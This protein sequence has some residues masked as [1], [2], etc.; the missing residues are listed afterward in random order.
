TDLPVTIGNGGKPI[1]NADERKN[2]CGPLP[3]PS[4]ANKICFSGVGKYTRTNSKRDENVVF[5]VDVEDR[6]EPGGTPPG[7]AAGGTT[8]PP[9]RY[10]FRLWIIKGNEGGSKGDPTTTDAMTL[11]NQVACYDPHI[12]TVCARTPDIDD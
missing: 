3:A 6:S 5:R 11:R 4:P 7:L 2:G 12:E 8:N 9:D 1:C 10:R